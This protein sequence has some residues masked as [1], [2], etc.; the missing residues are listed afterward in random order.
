MMIYCSGQLDLSY[1]KTFPSGFLLFKYHP[2]LPQCSGN[3]ETSQ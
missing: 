1:F 3:N 2:H